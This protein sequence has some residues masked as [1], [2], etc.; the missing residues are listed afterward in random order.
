MLD[1]QS[2]AGFTLL[3]LMTVV[4]IIAILAAIAYPSYTAYVVRNGESQAQQQMQLLATQLEQ[5]R[6]KALSYRQPTDG[7]SNSYYVPQGATASN[8]HYQIQIYDLKG[9]NVVNLNDSNALGT[10]WRM[11]ANHATTG[12]YSRGRNFYMD[13]L[14]N[15]CAL[16]STIPAA[17]TSN[18]CSNA[19]S[20]PWK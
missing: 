3:E 17:S 9:T 7:I 8:Y 15:R 14:G 5:W 2:G 1:F 12:I 18:M 10:Q 16:P 19:S 20:E 6:A 11:I 4:A 13:S